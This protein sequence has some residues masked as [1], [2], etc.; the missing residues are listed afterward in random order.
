LDLRFLRCRELFGDEGFEKISNAKI[1]IL[2]VGGVGSYA[3]DCLYRSGVSNITIVDYDKFDKTNQNRQ[4]GSNRVGESKV[5][6]LKSLYPKIEAI[7]QKIDIEWVRDFDFEPFDYVVDSQ[8][9]T[10]IKVEL[11]KRVYHKL[12][13]SAGSAKRW[14][15]SKIEVASI[16][17]T[18]GNALAKK[19]RSNLRRAGFRGDFRVVFSSEEERTNTQGSFVGVTGSF[20]LRICSE[21]IKDILKR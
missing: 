17:K 19:V 16:W 14:D 1:L 13:M 12:I 21:I 20:G 7:E 9:T 2:G 11:A 8:D 10:S 18:H 3:L 15:S 4:I 5:E 6:V